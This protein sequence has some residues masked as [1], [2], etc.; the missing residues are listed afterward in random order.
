MV[1]HFRLTRKSSRKTIAKW[2]FFHFLMKLLPRKSSQIGE[3]SSRQIQRTKK[4]QAP[5][6]LP[7]H[8]GG[9]LKVVTLLLQRAFGE[10]VVPKCAHPQKRVPN[11]VRSGRKL[12]MVGTP[13]C[14]AIKIWKITMFYRIEDTYLK[15]THPYGRFKLDKLVLSCGQSRHQKR[16]CQQ[17]QTLGCAD[18]TYHQLPTKHGS[19]RGASRLMVEN[20]FC[21]G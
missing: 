20:P 9:P 12:K 7:K 17:F 14:I 21:F 10:N 13:T 16:R 1:C 5:P 4:R 19:M 8:S 3:F 11:E 18:F 6:K 2:A 15:Q